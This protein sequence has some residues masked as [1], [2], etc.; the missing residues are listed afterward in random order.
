MTRRAS[1][2]LLN[3]WEQGLGEPAPMRALLLLQAA[4]PDAE[5]GDLQ[6]LTIGQRDAELLTLYEQLFGSELAGVV[7]CPNCGED[8]ELNFRAAQ[9]R[10]PA[11]LPTPDGREGVVTTPDGRRGVVTTPDGHRVGFRLPDSLDMLMITAEA[12]TRDIEDP[13][14]RTATFR[15]ALLA[16]CIED[17]RRVEELPPALVDEIIARMAQ[18][19]P[20]ADVRLDVT[21]PACHH[22]WQT[23]FDIVSYLWRM[24]D[25]WAV[26]TLYEVHRLASAYGWRE[27]DILSM[28]ARRRQL[29][30]DM[31]GGRRYSSEG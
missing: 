2:T 21:C 16:R 24:V 23:L 14:Q 1:S 5:V 9:V 28:S 25:D 13:L 18:A 4:H 22:N 19:D 11:A 3:A 17:A 30:L 12:G 26:N 27:A 7:T 29:Y 15:R 31:I 10:A 6:H 8:L 20:Q